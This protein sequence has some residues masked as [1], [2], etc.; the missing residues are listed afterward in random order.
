MS[1]PIALN[2]R[3]SYQWIPIVPIPRPLRSTPA[4]KKDQAYHAACARY[5]LSQQNGTAAW[6]NWFQSNYSENKAYAIDSLWGSTDD[7]RVFLGDGAAQTSR[8][9]FKYPIISPML[10]RLVGGVDN[11]AINAQAE[12]VT[13]YFAQTRREAKLNERLAMSLA[14]RSSTEVAQ[15]FAP[16]GISPSADETSRIFDS[17]YQDKIVKGENALMQMLASR[18]E[19]ATSKRRAGTDMALSG[20]AAMRFFVNGENIDM[21]FCDPGEVGWSTSALKPDLTD[22][23]AVWHCPLMDVSMIAERWP[24][25]EKQIT[26]L[27]YWANQVY[28]NNISGGYWPQSQPRIYTVY[29]KDEIVVERGFVLV[30]GEPEYVTVNAVDPDTGE[31]KYTDKDLIDPPEEYGMYYQRWTAKEKREK[32]RTRRAQQLRYCSFLP[33]EYM[34]GNYTSGQQF[35]ARM[36]DNEKTLQTGVLGDMVFD[37]GICPLQEPDPDDQYSVR[38]PIKFST[39]RYIGGHVVSPISAAIDPQRWMNQITSDLAWRLRTAGGKVLVM[40]KAAYAGSPQSEEEINQR[41]KEGDGPVILDGAPYNSVNNATGVVDNSPGAGFYNL[42]AQLPAMAGIANQAVGIYPENYGAPGSPNQLVGTMQLQLQQAGVQ[43]QPY[44]AAV[45]DL[46]RQGYQFIANA[47]KQFYGRRPW[48]LSRMTAEEDMEALIQSRDMQIEQF[49]VQVEMVPDNQQLRTITDQQIIPGLMQLGMLDPV[50]AADLLGR[51]TPH[52]AYSA[53]RRFT[54]QAAEA[55]AKMAEQAAMQQQAD[56]LAAEQQE[57]DGQEMEVAKLEQQEIMN[58]AK[59]GQKSAQPFLQAKADGL[60]P[61]LMDP[62]I[63]QPTA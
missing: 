52:D 17:T 54:K 11:I 24:D 2:N 3:G 10:T 33:W 49:R 47:G 25:K 40:D 44:Y 55:N 43:Q 4:D 13:Q 38:F 21:E 18:Y 62:S 63:G 35:S 23:E 8:I 22:A 7:V 58:N 60:N 16:M 59:L 56:A 61:T 19:F 34:P 5:Y 50:T 20:L 51:S 46:F 41:I 27:E 42:L 14:A 9:P 29:W 12:L 31:V 26:R 57:I 32:K 36:V 37:Y 48:L 28:A 1:A 15:A 39:W 30:D 53:A 45:A 6:I